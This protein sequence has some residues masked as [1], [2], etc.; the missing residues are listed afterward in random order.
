MNHPPRDADVL[1]L[2]ALRPGYTEDPYPLLAELRASAPVRQVELLGLRAWL[3]TRHADV[4]AALGNPSISTDPQHANPE[5][6]AW[7][8]V[9]AGLRGPLARSVLMTDDPDHARLR[10]LIGKEFTPR[11]VEAL[12]PRVEEICDE[13]IADFRDLGKADL[14]RDFAAV[15]PLTVISELFGIP[16]ADRA[17]F[18]QWALVVGGMDE[19]SPGQQPQVFAEMS[20]YLNDLID[21]KSARRGDARETDLLAALIAVRDAG[22]RLSHQELLGTATV[23]LL[24]GHSTTVNLISNGMLALLRRPDQLAALRADPSQVDGAVEEFLRYDGP[25]ANPS[26]RFTTQP[27]RVGDVAIPANEVVLL[28]LAS[29]NR[30]PGQFGEPDVLDIRR[31]DHHAHLA[32]GHGMHYCLGAPLARLEARV[33]IPKLLAT[34]PHIAVDETAELRWRVGVPARGL[35]ELPVTFTPARSA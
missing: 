29:A 6:Q 20:A 23:L 19:K 5:A 16:A 9:A 2:D 3:V 18:R 22:D 11:R 27:T 21:V 12:R 26:L 25:A 30:D 28:S 17:R 33:A 14:I 32:F 1:D 7:P 15:L 8:Q 13:L 31:A 35:H 4:L 10:R 24:A 34:C